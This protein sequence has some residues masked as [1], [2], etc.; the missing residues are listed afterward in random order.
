MAKVILL[1]A[2]G[3]IGRRAAQAL[4]ASPEVEVLTLAG[5][6]RSKIEELAHQLGGPARS[7]RIDVQ[8]SSSLVRV[9]QGHD[10]AM[11]TIGPSYLYEVPLAQAAIKAKVPY[12]S[13]CDD[14][15]AVEDVLKLDD[16]AKQNGVTVLTGM[17]WTPGLTNIMAKKGVSLLDQADEVHVSWAGAL[18]DVEGPA[19]ILHWFHIMTGH[20][21][22]F[23]NGRVAT[24]RAGSG[25]KR[26]PFP[27][28][29]GM[30]EVRH[31]GHPETVTIPRFIP[32]LQEV[33]LCGGIGVPLHTYL[34]ILLTRIG[35]TRTPRGKAMLLK[36]VEPLLPLLKK[37]GKN[38][39][40][41]SGTHVLVRGVRDGEPTEIE[42]TAADRMASITALPQVVGALMIARGEIKSPG[43]IAPEAPGGPD[44]DRFL[45][46]LEG[47]GITVHLDVR[48]VAE[49]RG[50]R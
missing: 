20:V 6:N 41:V 10:V 42:L 39:K 5:R 46:L 50:R 14:Y 43:V 19:A 9:I 36:I 4:A 1:G 2:T 35:L 45:T 17:G 49:T 21:P 15:D 47:Y 7:V 28:P 33:T 44:P 30:F 11:S 8:D 34:S 26:V 37:L 22:T 23:R 31:V 24:V 38:V 27:Q 13:V 29:I 40:P 32:G 25:P 16:E 3:D 48:P 12:V 18:A